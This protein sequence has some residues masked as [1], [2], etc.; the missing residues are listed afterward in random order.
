MRKALS[1]VAVFL[2]VACNSVLDIPEAHPKTG[3]GTDTTPG[4]DGECGDGTKDCNGK[5]V[6][7][8]DP[9]TGCGGDSCDPCQLPHATVRC[10]DGAC[11]IRQ[12]QDNFRNCNEQTDDGCEAD[13][14]SDTS[15]C[16][17]CGLAC[18][19]GLKCESSIC[20][21]ENDGDCGDE[22]TCGTDD[23]DRGRCYCNGDL[24]SVGSA[25]D[26]KACA[27]Q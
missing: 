7:T 8:N 1:L 27:F 19:G 14:T 15:N 4:N 10:V 16:S 24:C 21:C 23:D 25:C 5:C 12:C 26:G 2:V 6:S 9:A 20:K 18:G 11:A 22:A 13:I 17:E 3:L